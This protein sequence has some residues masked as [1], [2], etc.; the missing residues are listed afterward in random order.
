MRRANKEAKREEKNR[1]IGKSRGEQP[2]QMANSRLLC[3]QPFPDSLGQ[4][5]GSSRAAKKR[6]GCSR[7]VQF[8]SVCTKRRPPCCHLILEGS[9]HLASGFN[10][11]YH[12][13]PR[14][15]F[16]KYRCDRGAWGGV[17]HAAGVL[18]QQYVVDSRDSGPEEEQSGQILPRKSGGLKNVGRTPT[19]RVTP[20]LTLN[21]C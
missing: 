3:A 10:K 12:T 4:K 17:S 14:L 13:K 2:P 9:W 6:P 20:L 15:A 19:E 16:S 5:S 8:V 7:H 1:K 18:V 11:R 21:R